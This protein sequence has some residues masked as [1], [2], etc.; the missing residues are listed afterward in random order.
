MFF[1][2]DESPSVRFFGGGGKKPKAPPAPPAPVKQAEVRRVEERATDARNEE[3]KRR[4][5]GRKATLKFGIE[6]ELT[7]RLG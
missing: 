7:K 3:R 6:K 5:P 4:P 1:S 2:K